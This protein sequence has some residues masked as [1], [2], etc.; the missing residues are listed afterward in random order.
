M[1]NL[2]SFT[3]LKDILRENKKKHTHI[4]NKSCLNYLSKSYEVPISKIDIVNKELIKKPKNK[5]CI[6]NI[7]FIYIDFLIVF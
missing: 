4:N 2:L 3:N 7:N 6:N 1:G 5:L